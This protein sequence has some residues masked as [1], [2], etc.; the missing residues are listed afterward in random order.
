[1]RRAMLS[2]WLCVLFVIVSSSPEHSSGQQAQSTPSPLWSGSQSVDWW[3]AFKFNAETFPRPSTTVPT[4][5]FGG[6]PGGTRKY[7]RIGQSYVTAS[8]THTALVKGTGFLGDSLADPLGATFNEVYNGDLSYLVWNDQFYRSPVLAC[9]GSVGNA[10]GAKWAHSKGL[11]AWN[12]DGDGFILQVTTPSWPGAGS[13][14][15]PRPKDGNSLGCVNDDNVD[16]SQGFFALRLTKDDLLKVLAALQTEGAVTDPSNLQIAKIGGPQEVRDA[17]T[18][19]GSPNAVA[20]F[21]QQTLSTGVRIIAKA[22]G[23]T[24][25]PWQFVSA[26]LG[27]VP[28]RIATFWQG[29]LIYSTPGRTQPDCWPA[30]L[31]SVSPGAVQIVTTGIWDGKTIGLTGTSQ[32]DE[33]GN[34]LGANHA[35]LGVSTGNGSPLTIFSDMNQ[36]GAI[37]PRGKL[38]CSS[39]QNARGGLFFVVEDAGLH[40]SVSALLTG[41]IAPSK[42]SPVPRA[43]RATGGSVHR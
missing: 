20:T 35:K 14:S 12:D 8:S 28:L 15:H 22:G 21:T 9:E 33:A 16:L 41:K 43:I 37:S 10:C 18:K 39:S 25:P 17:A 23:L 11:L 2:L 30:A 1:M 3:F 27:K 34:S 26:V 7:T 42:A 31:H 4:C 40:K 13:N 19:L 6:K 24:A 32:K 38:T 36:D 5:M 29:A